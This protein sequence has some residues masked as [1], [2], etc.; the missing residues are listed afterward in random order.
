V[1]YIKEG[2]DAKVLAGG[3]DAW[4]QAGY[5]AAE[6]TQAMGLMVLDPSVRG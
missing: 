1:K 5:P 3:V 6:G 2:Y 4:K